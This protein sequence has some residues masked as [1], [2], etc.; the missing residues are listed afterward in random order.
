MEAG[1]VASVFGVR[2]SIVSGG[3]ACVAGTALLAFLLP[4]FVRYEKPRR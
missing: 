1:A 2:A 4:A 3:V